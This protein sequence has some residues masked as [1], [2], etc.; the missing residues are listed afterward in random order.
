[1]D[2]EKYL[3]AENG[4]FKKLFTYIR[5]KIIAKAELA[6]LMQLTRVVTESTKQTG[7]EINTPRKRI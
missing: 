5:T 3:N 6:T 7:L 1:M 4:V 2:E